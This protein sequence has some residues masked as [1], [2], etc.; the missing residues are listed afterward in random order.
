[1]LRKL[2]ISTTMALVLTTG[3]AQAQFGSRIVF[4]PT[5]YR[6]NLVTAVRNVQQVNNQLRQLNHEVEMLTNQARDLRNLDYSAAGEIEARLREIELLV[7]NA[8]SIALSVEEMEAVLCGLPFLTIMWVSAMMRR[9]LSCAT[10]G[11]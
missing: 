1:M 3:A 6:Q 10:S 9:F 5:N 8:G 7:A 4:D 11:N 2:I